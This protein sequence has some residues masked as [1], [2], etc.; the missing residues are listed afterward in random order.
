M[1]ERPETE[2]L[3][4]AVAR[5][6]ENEV[7]PVVSDPRLAFRLLIAANLNTIVAAELKNGGAFSQA[8]LSRLRSLLP[9]AAA[10]LSVGQSD[11]TD[12]ETMIALNRVLAEKLRG[13]E[14]LSS[15]TLSHIRAHLKQTLHDKLTVSNPRFDLRPD[16]D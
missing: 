14:V 15:E 5:F 16:V 7:R 1:V 8:E 10:K 6:L 13:G 3:L 9:E 4:L 2:A 12:S 11:Q